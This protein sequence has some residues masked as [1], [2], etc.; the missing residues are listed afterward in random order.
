[1][2]DPLS[3]LGFGIEVAKQIRSFVGSR[4]TMTPKVLDYS[5]SEWEITKTV[6]I[7][8]K[9]D[10]PL[11][12]IQVVIWSSNDAKVGISIENQEQGHSERMGSMNI[13]T[14]SLIIGGVA[15]GR[16]CKLLQ[17]NYLSTKSGK[18]IF[19][20]TNDSVQLVLEVVKFSKQPISSIAKK[21]GTV[22]ISFTPPFNMQLNSISVLM[23][24]GG[25]EN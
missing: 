16:N 17:I 21:D 4:V 6:I 20:S 7:S 15:N 19:F 12:D 10:N 9:T 1:M 11:F 18:R 24:K 14:E 23:I 13:S 8:N 2:I 22:A 5:K 3:A 25:G